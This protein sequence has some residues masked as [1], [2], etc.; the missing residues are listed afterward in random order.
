MRLDAYLFSVVSPTNHFSY[1]AVSCRVCTEPVKKGAVLCSHCSLIAHS[2]CAGRAPP[3]CDLRSKLLMHAQFAERGSP[4]DIFL[5]RLPTPAS[6]GVGA[7]SSRGSERTN[8]PSSPPHPPVAYKVLSPFKRSHTS[9]SQDPK[10]SNSSISLAGA[11]P[12]SVSQR[13][14]QSQRWPQ[15]RKSILPEGGVIR[16][17]LST[18]LT[19]Q[20]DPSLLSD[21]PRPQSMISSISSSSPH[22]PQSNSIRSLQTAAESISSRAARVDASISAATESSMDAVVV[23]RRVSVHSGTST[24]PDGMGEPSVANA[25]SSAPP[26]SSASAS[27]PTMKK[28]P[29]TVVGAQDTHR[30]KRGRGESKSS[31]GNCAIQ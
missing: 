5:T 25:P 18:I 4:A 3:T 24:I 7:S 20:R 14:Q 22:S 8:S 12:P 13:P 31:N 10:K 2:K 17:K 11:T 26:A 21:R 16:R 6:D 9:L 23:P 19:R 30:T 15:P 1:P 28:V 27:A 29:V